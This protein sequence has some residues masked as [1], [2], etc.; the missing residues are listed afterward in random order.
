MIEMLP[1][2]LK[3]MSACS[4]ITILIIVNKKKYE[5]LTLPEKVMLACSLTVIVS[6]IMFILKLI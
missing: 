5:E 3:I 6:T 2:W 4:V 1:I